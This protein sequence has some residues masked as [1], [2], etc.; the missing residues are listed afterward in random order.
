[1]AL[2]AAAQINAIK[3]IANIKLAS[4][5]YGWADGCAHLR[6]A[7]A[8]ARGILAR[9]MQRALA[10]A[11][12]TWVEAAAEARRLRALLRRAVAMFANRALAGAWNAW[13]EHTRRAAWYKLQLRRCAARWMNRTLAQTF[14]R[15]ADNVAEKRRQRVAL[16]R[17]LM[18]RA[19]DLRAEVFSAWAALWRERKEGLDRLRTCIARKRISMKLFLQWY[20]DAFDED[21]KFTLRRILNTTEEEINSPYTQLHDRLCHF[22]KAMKPSGGAM[23]P[24]MSPAPGGARTLTPSLFH[25][26]HDERSVIHSYSF[27]HENRTI[28]LGCRVRAGF[29]N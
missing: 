23:R 10:E 18:S 4:A 29:E 28:Q 14:G 25:L 16:G 15:W 6:D 20:W 17:Y 1:M 9:I 11:W 3:R 21:I 24:L 27:M 13:V 7:A 2:A 22:H 8:R 12:N 5:F 26:D 19:R